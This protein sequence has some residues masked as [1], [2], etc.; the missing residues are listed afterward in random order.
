[1]P[2]KRIS[3]SIEDELIFEKLKKKYRMTNDEALSYCVRAAMSKANELE[4]I[5][6]ELDRSLEYIKLLVK[7][8]KDLPKS[9][10][11]EQMKRT[12]NLDSR[13]EDLIEEK[14]RKVDEKR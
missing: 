10:D 4:E 12:V 8:N 14:L 6:K 5:K 2:I 7:V 9:E 11:Y 3:M 1:M 13:F